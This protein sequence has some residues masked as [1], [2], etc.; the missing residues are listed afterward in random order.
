MIFRV[1][2][3][4]WGK[5]AGIKGRIADSLLFYITAMFKCLV[6][7]KHDVVVTLTS[8]PV[9]GILGWL[10]T[11]C[12]R[13]KHVHWCMDMFPDTAVAMGLMKEEGFI[14]KVCATLMHRY[15]STC[16]AVLALGPYMANRLKKYGV[17]SEHLHI[18]PVWADGEN[19]KPINRE[20]NW[21]IKIHKLE[22]KF[23][24]M[25]SG[26]MELGSDLDFIIQAPI[27]LRNHN[28]IRFVFISEGPEFNKLKKIS[29]KKGLDNV[30]FLPY[31]SRKDLSQSL[32][33]GDVHIVTIK[34][35]LEGLRLPCKTFGIIAVGKPII[36]VGG[37]DTEVADLIDEYDIGLRVRAGD[38]DSLVDAILKIKNDPAMR[39]DMSKR[40]RELFE[41]KYHAD[42]IIKSFE[43]IVTAIAK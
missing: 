25:Y 33:A 3:A 27:K 22:D 19:V 16:K 32:S 34:K 36:Y 6:L 21:F 4:G 10:L 17:D 26:N 35:G 40:A 1:G 11:M 24:I 5:N 42:V 29:Q 41:T 39:K 14:Y 7:P 18:V 12:K 2:T 15:I 38:P 31:Q 43:E 8:P 13:T 37:R 23:V 28:D 9:I 30:L 20:N